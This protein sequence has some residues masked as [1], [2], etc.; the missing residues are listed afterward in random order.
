MSNIEHLPREKGDSKKWGLVASCNK[1]GNLRWGAY[2]K[3][4]EAM[5]AAKAQSK[6]TGGTN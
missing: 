1:E 2:S 4:K 6:D 5:R 3:V